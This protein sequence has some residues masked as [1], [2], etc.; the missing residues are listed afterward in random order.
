MRHDFRVLDPTSFFQ[1]SGS[2]KQSHSTSIKVIKKTK[3]QAVEPDYDMDDDLLD[4]DILRNLVD[5]AEA[6]QNVNSSTS[7][8]VLTSNNKEETI[9]ASSKP[10]PSPAAKKAK[11]VE[12][13]EPKK[14]QT[15]TK[16]KT[17]S[18]KSST[19]KEVKRKEE[20]VTPSAPAESS[21]ASESATAGTE[22]SGEKAKKAPG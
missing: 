21:K 18:K 11:E 12:N 5:E 1:S 4:D 20:K 6:M 7:N 14:E 22:E 19:P 9:P 15:P 2:V 8:G 13:V 16:K 3:V 17:P 10:N